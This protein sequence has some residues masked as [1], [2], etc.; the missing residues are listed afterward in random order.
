MG[1]YRKS[2]QLLIEGWF[3]KIFFDTWPMNTGSRNN[4]YLSR[5]PGKI[6]EKFQD[7]EKVPVGSSGFLCCFGSVLGTV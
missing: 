7:Y 5:P 1:Y 4:P 2:N 6:M 3:N